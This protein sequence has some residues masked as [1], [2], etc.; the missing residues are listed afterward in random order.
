MKN[1]KEFAEFMLC[2]MDVEPDNELT[3]VEIDKVANVLARD[4]RFQLAYDSITERVAKAYIRR[5]NEI[6]GGK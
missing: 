6:K 1:Y 3:A 5:L 4:A 2:E